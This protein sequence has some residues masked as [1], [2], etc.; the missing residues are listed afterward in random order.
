[1]GWNMELAEHVPAPLSMSWTIL[2]PELGLKL[3]T[4]SATGMHWSHN[5]G[6]FHEHKQIISKLG[7]SPSPQSLS[8]VFC[9]RLWSHAPVDVF[10]GVY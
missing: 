4:Q 1:M 5:L 9:L 6:T 3:K 7:R 2:A 10:A 8:Q